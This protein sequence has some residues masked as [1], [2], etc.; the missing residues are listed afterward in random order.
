MNRRS[1]PWGAIEAFIVAART[2]GFRD[3][4][5]K[6]GLSPSAFSRRI[7]ALEEHI[8]VQL[9]DRSGPSPQ[10]TAAGR[11]YLLRLEPGY[12]APRA[13]TEWMAPDPAHRPLRV[14]ISQSLAISWLLP[15]L[16]RFQTREPGIELILQTRSGDIDLLGGA[17]DVGILFG[18]GQWRHLVS[19]PLMAVTA[20][21]VCAERL[22]YDLPPPARIEDLPRHRLLEAVYPA[23]Q[24]RDW[25]HWAGQPSWSGQERLRF[26][27]LQVLYEA[28]A[29]GLGVALGVRP[30]VTPFLESGRLA[31]AFPGT[32]AIPGHYHIATAP[33]RRH[34]RA[35][36][37]FWQ[38]L[39][40]EAGAPENA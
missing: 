11:R 1:P 37:V 34:D 4:A 12:Q 26:D 3:A 21:V 31:V 23:N 22:A 38:W 27:S 36:Q 33:G 35:V 18:D 28:A 16:H 14:G 40:E 17:A 32:W 20:E 10:L 39:K 13:A 19:E 2:G 6:L 5:E 9:F 8:G 24:W 15:R 25:F 7:Q 30:L 29:R